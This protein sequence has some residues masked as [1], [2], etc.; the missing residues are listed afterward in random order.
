MFIARQPI[1]DKSLNIYGYELLFRA[2][3]ESNTFSNATSDSASAVVLGGLLEQG[4]DRVVGIR[5]AFVNFD[6]D[7]IM[8]D[9]I[10]LIKPDTL[11]IEILET[12]TFDSSLLSRIKKLHNKGYKIALD[13]FEEDYFTFPAISIA[14]IIKYDI[15]LT[16]LDTLHREVKA[17]IANKKICLAEKI[18]TEEEFQKAKAMGFQLFQGY[19]FSKPKIVTIGSNTKKSSK[20]IYAQI[21]SEIKKEEFSYDKITSIIESDV[22]LSYRLLCVLSHKDEKI[23]YSSIRNALVRMGAL[24][25]ERWINVLMLQNMANDKPDEVIRLSL[26]RSK[27]SEYISERSSFCNRKD[28]A[29][30]MSLFSLLDVILDCSMEEALE[31]LAISSDI[32]DALVYGTGVFR[33]LCMLMQSYENGNWNDVDGYVKKIN[34]KPANLTEGY[35]SAIKWASSILDFY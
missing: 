3:A 28:E 30:M 14:D 22:N 10:E 12:V 26:V 33:P 13:D 24:E 23:N 4:I 35:L 19:F 17:A 11:V 32:F 9:M 18:E 31:G 8:S 15:M 5:K 6:Y 16:P 7:F 29:S 34:L 21:L 1:F 20:A 25:I 27:F 2:N